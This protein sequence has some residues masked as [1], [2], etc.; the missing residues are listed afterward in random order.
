MGFFYVA[1]N[2]FCFYSVNMIKLRWTG[3]IGYR[4]ST[5]EDAMA[6]I[7][8]DSVEADL[9]EAGGQDVDIELSTFGGNFFDGIQ[10]MNMLKGYAGKTRVFI[11]SIVASAGTII[12][13]GADEIIARPSSVFMIHNAMMMAYGDHVELRKRADELENYTKII[14]E[15]YVNKTGK[16]E[17][18]IRALMDEETYLYGE[19]IVTEGFADTMEEDSSNETPINKGRVKQIVAS[20]LKAIHKHTPNNIKDFE[21][22]LR[23]AGYSKSQAVA[24]ASGGFRAIESMGKQKS[25]ENTVTKQEILE[26]LKNL[27]ANNEI[28]LPEIANHLGLGEQL[29]DNSAIKSL[30]EE[31]TK[32]K[33]TV[34]SLET[35][36]ED[37]RASV[38]SARLDKEFGTDNSMR[39]YAEDILSGSSIADL[40]E[41]IK[42]FKEKPL[43]KRIAAES[44]DSFSPANSVEKKSDETKKA[45]G[46]TI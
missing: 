38:V 24:I 37:N 11:N 10:I 12:S 28:N 20:K 21:K 17:E 29:V 22:H 45:E 2:L 43:A 15:G 9:K 32:L 5:G 34:A 36:I 44:A 40:D 4:Y 14:A 1:N 27:K 23:N 26:G 16:D 18:E 7:T 19:E 13:M 31:N 46:L 8:P 35:D 33:E 39:E 30:T 6:G 25:K 41:G 3:E 42:N